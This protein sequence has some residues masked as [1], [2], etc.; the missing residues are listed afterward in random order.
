MVIL[1]WQSTCLVTWR[2]TPISDWYSIPILC[3]FM[4]NFTSHLFTQIFRRIMMEPKR[5]SAPT[6]PIHMVMNWNLLTFFDADH[7]HNQLMRHSI[8]GIMIL[9]EVLQFCG[10][11]SIRVALPIQHILP[12]LLLCALP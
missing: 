4:R 8:T 1:N 9:L 11:A 7:A 2:S 10:Q 3:L 6:S 5:R 12:S